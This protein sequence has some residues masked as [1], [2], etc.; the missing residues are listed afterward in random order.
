MKQLLLVISIASLCACG[1][2]D[3]YVGGEGA[4]L[5]SYTESRLTDDR[6]RVTFI[7]EPNATADQVKDLALLRAAELTLANDYDWFRVVNQ[8]TQE[9]A[10]VAPAAVTTTGPVQQV[11][12]D[13]GALGCTTTVTPAYTGTQVVTVQQDNR[14]TTSIEF[15]MG[16]GSLRDPTVAYNADELH[17]SLTRRY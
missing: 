10:T 2:S 14:F 1:T 3:P 15:V 4:G 16:D 5:G 13:C 11:T 9:Q 6:Y 7:G 12:R 17:E 8:E